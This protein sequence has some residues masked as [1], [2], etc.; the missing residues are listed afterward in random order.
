MAGAFGAAPGRGSEM[1]GPDR[2]S[3]LDL[4]RRAKAYWPRIVAGGLVVLC[5]VGAIV[6]I[7]SLSGGKEKDPLASAVLNDP[8]PPPSDF[9]SALPVSVSQPRQATPPA[10]SPPVSDP[11]AD[12]RAAALK[13]PLLVL[14]N[15]N[16]N[17]SQGAHGGEAGAS[18]APERPDD[19]LG[20]AL[21]PTPLQGVN[22]VEGPDPNFTVGAGRLI[23][24]VQQ[25]RFNSSAPGGV[26][27][28]V[29]NDVYGETG[30]VRV[31]D[32]GS[33]VIG[34]AS[35]AL[36][37]GLDRAFVLW[38]TIRTPPLYDQ[39]GIPHQYDVAVNSPATEENGANGLP[40]DVE[41]HTWRK[42]GG[43]FAISLVQGLTGSLSSLG[44]SGNGTTNNIFPSFGQGAS[45][46]ADIWLSKMINIPD[47]LTRLEGS[48]CGVLVLRDLNMK[49]AYRLVAQHGM[50]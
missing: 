42:L 30:K 16:R 10:P 8:G 7:R 2:V 13:S 46:A 45:S 14:A 29:A 23:A 49:A 31:I 44:N 43:V 3:P 37:N 22:V 38:Q 40:G 24:C 18:Q 21:R 20:A 27:A 12:A 6:L 4:G 35:H 1:S 47:V 26:T 39:G 36:E 33:T 17:G 5:L 28:V 11:I 32:K 34:T 25:V 19:P 48:Q 41:R 9:A 50:H 15:N